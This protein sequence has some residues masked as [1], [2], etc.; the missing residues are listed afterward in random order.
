MKNITPLFD[1]FHLPSLLRKRR[2]PS[3]ILKDKKTL[4]E[5][6]SIGQL[7]KCFGNL[8]PKS[9]LK[10]SGEKEHSRLRIFS[11][12]N[13]FWAF[14]AQVL[15]PD[16]GCME[17]VKKIQAHAA[18]RSEKPI[19]SSTSAYCQA[20]ANLKE[21]ELQDILNHTAEQLDNDAESG[22]LNG[23]RVVV[24]DGT[25]LSMP[26]T[27]ANQ[28][29]WPQHKNQKK[30]CGFPSARAC[31]CFSL[32]T[33]GVLSV[34]LGNKKSAELPLLRKQSDTFR[35]DDI[36]LGDAMFNSFFDFATL[37]A[38]G[39][40]SVS[41]LSHRKPFTAKNSE[42]I[43]GK[44]DL[45]GVWK[46]PK[47]NK[48]SAYT[49]EEL[50]ALPDEIPVR[51][52]YVTVTK[53]G[54]RTG[55]FYIVT[56]LLDP[57]EYPREKIENLYLERWDVE[58]FIRDIKTTMDMDILRCKTP[59]MVRKEIIMH[60]IVYNSIRM[61]MNTAAEKK[62]IAVR[63]I[64]FKGAVQSL[65]QWEPQLNQAQLSSKEMR[66]MVSVLHDVIA[67]NLIVDRP[68]RSEPRC[69]KRRKKP[70]PHLT[71]PRGEMKKKMMEDRNCAKGA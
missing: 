51:Q 58:L 70:Y 36:C 17:V 48:K 13:T 65:R 31:C 63:K 3:Q 23:R 12:E 6:K 44:N 54:F 20:R 30:G 37:K 22:R 26:D 27:P 32:A 38:K 67:D 25:G 45:L 18:V 62:G 53:P 35:K 24:V 7:Q 66:R 46:K 21:S 64:S 60:F 43:L 34:E 69:V 14:F 49:K 19:C 55:S 61:L 57:I 59:E 50:A 71:V 29:V 10:Q 9:L 52:I 1:N 5:S 39:V 4:L 40:D 16:K 28:A 8:I 47:W 11:K 56:T 15:E 41:V 33:G 2:S 42:K 68:E